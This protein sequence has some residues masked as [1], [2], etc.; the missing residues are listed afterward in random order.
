MKLWLGLGAT[1]H[2]IKPGLERIVV[3]WYLLSAKAGQ[4]QH[5]NQ[6]RQGFRNNFEYLGHA[7]HP[8]SVTRR[9][10][11]ATPPLRAEC[12]AWVNAA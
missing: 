3:G 6:R 1:V 12:N 8:R 11:H 5:N 4:S 2:R 10:R 9:R 7:I